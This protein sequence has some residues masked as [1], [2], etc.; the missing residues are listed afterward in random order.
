MP[1]RLSKR[2]QVGLRL[3]LRPWRINKLLEDQPASARIHRIVPAL[4]HMQNQ[5]T[6]QLQLSLGKVEAHR[7]PATARQLLVTISTPPLHSH[8]M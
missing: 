5:T 3:S 4:I 6:T 1:L 2:R 8:T 7:H